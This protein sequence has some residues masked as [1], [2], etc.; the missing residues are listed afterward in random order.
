MEEALNKTQL[1]NWFEGITD[2][3]GIGKEAKLVRN[4]VPIESWLNEEF[5]SGPSSYQIYPYWKQAIIKVF[6]SPERINEVILGGSIGTGKGEPIS[7][8]IPTPDGPVRLGDLKVGDFV[9]NE[10]GKP[11]K[12][13]GVYD[14]G[15]LTTYKVTFTDNSYLIVDGSHLWT[16]Y[17]FNNGNLYEETFNTERMYN[18]MNTDGLFVKGKKTTKYSNYRLPITEPIQYNKRDL[19]VHPYV[20]GAL[21]ADGTLGDKSR[22]CWTKSETDIVDEMRKYIVLRH[23]ENDKNR[24]TYF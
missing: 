13:I 23:N 21:I 8:L 24:I 10:E 6:N 7:T 2:F 3:R 1:G 22:I 12:V 4:I 20:L 14:R 19:N 9:F 18:A 17:R 16:L 15:R 11:T 5:Y